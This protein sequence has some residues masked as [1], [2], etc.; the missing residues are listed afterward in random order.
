MKQFLIFIIIFL[1]L[2][3]AIHSVLAVSV[4]LEVITTKGGGGAGA[5]VAPAPAPSAP[6]PSEVSP[7]EIPQV[8]TPPTEAPPTE[9]PLT[10]FSLIEV[11]SLALPAE[12]I[13]SV[14]APVSS[15]GPSQSAPILP[16]VVE[17]IVES[18]PPA[19]Q[20]VVKTAE[21]I[22]IKTENT[23]RQLRTNPKIQKI[24]TQP[25]VDVSTKTVSTVAVGAAATSGLMGFMPLATSFSDFG[26]LPSRLFLFAIGFFV[27]RKRKNWGVIYDS[28][29]KQPLDPAYVILKDKNGNEIETRITDI[30]GRFGFLMGSGEYYIEANKTH[31]QFPSI[32]VPGARDEIYDNLYHGEF[33]KIIDPT[34]MSINIPMDPIDVDWNEVAKKKY[35][36]F[37]YKWE[38]FKR[39]LPDILFIFGFLL[40]VLLWILRPTLFNQIMIWCFVGLWILR[41]FGFKQRKWG[42]ILDKKT[43]KPISFSALR[44]FYE[45]LSQQIHFTTADAGGRYYAL[46]DKGKYDVSVEEK[47]D[48]GYQP[49]KKYQGIK[50][51]KPV[52][53]KDFFVDAPR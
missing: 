44:V 6:A 9:V 46:V 13:S 10:E 5:G 53:N 16:L 45:K 50:L 37:N 27:R 11:L 38:L 17:K 15:F 42:L 41:T 24:V 31:Y 33:L 39:W 36:K 47:I 23:V 14:S 8:E 48:S 52:L 12:I 22:I 4:N 43:K 7:A 32:K 29:T 25:V 19:V 18:M 40:I 20:E 49:I 21:Q 3:L 51:K 35:I 2:I 26:V 1:V 34:V 30:N 28:V